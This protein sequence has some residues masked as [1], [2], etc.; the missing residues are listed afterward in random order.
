MKKSN[1]GLGVILNRF[2]IFSKYLSQGKHE[3]LFS[4][5][6]LLG[7]SN[8][9]KEV[10][11]KKGEII[12]RSGE[13]NTK[14]FQV[15]TGLLRSY[16][17]D[18]NGKENIFMF[19][20]EGWVIADTCA[21]NTASILFIDA[22]EDSS[23]L[24]LD[25]NLEREKQHVDALAKRLNVLQN[26]ILMLISTNAIKRYEHFIKTYPSI[27]QRVPQHMIA[28]YIGVNPETLSAAK[29]QR[30]KRP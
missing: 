27:A 29:S 4:L 23:V 10:T 22:I 20:P 7:K 1:S 9:V 6:V 25:K 11:I 16:S 28:S 17:I 26:R 24:V 19:A 5:P 3:L 18:E 2:F 30:I 15:R 21:P 8:S 12:Q 14:V 13:L